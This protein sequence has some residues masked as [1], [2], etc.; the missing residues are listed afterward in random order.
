M[1]IRHRLTNRQ[2]QFVF[3]I[4]RICILW[5][6]GH[7]SIKNNYDP[8]S[9]KLAL[10]LVCLNLSPN[11]RARSLFVLMAANVRSDIAGSRRKKGKSNIQWLRDKSN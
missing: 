5:H 2:F 3:E 11:K 1:L 10:M 8:H 9:P 4:Q 6:E 7:V